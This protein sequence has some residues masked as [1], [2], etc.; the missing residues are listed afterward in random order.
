MNFGEEEVVP[1]AVRWPQ[2]RLD[3]DPNVECSCNLDRARF[4]RT[5]S[6][7]DHDYHHPRIAQEL[8]RRRD[9]NHDGQTISSWSPSPHWSWSQQ[10]DGGRALAVPLHLRDIWTKGDVVLFGHSTRL[11]QDRNKS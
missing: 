2:I 5:P 4:H 6:L 10:G 8:H 3:M 9:N 7:S 1:I 11:W